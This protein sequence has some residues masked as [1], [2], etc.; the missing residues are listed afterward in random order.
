[1]SKNFSYSDLNSKCLDVDGLYMVVSQ[2]YYLPV[3][4]S[5]AIS[6]TILLTLMKDAS[7]WMPPAKT[8]KYF[9]HFTGKGQE[10]L[11]EHLQKAVV[12]KGKKW[13]FAA[14]STPDME[15]LKNAILYIDDDV[16]KLGLLQRVPCDFRITPA[17]REAFSREKTVPILNR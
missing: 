15:W 11:F 9:F 4:S 1:M 2:I 16:D 6:R 8:P 10:A 3:R 7:Y 5:T 14:G 12:T 13:I 17:E